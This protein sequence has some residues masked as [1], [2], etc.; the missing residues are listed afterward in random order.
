L[1]FGDLVVSTVVSRPLREWT[2][3]RKR[4]LLWL[5]CSIPV[6]EEQSIH[7]DVGATVERTKFQFPKIYLSF[8]II[9]K[10][11]KETRRWSHRR[12]GNENSD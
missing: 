8:D 6:C 1:E 9:G 5:T 7:A 3:P 2:A 11:G 10:T 4:E 12:H